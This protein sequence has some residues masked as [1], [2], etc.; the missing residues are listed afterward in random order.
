MKKSIRRIL[1]CSVLIFGC[2]AEALALDKPITAY[3]LLNHSSKSKYLTSAHL[4]PAKKPVMLMNIKLTSQQKQLLQEAN[5]ENKEASEPTELKM[6]PSQYDRGMNG[7]P[8]LDQGMH[9]T[10]AT[11]ANTAAIDALLGKGDYVS[12]LCQLSLGNYFEQKAYL[13]S[14]W[15]GSVGPLVLYQILGFGIINKTNQKIKSCGGLTDYPD[16]D[17]NNRG[18]S[19]SLD[20][21]KELS[22]DLSERLDWQTLLSFE[23]RFAW[24]T[25]NSIKPNALLYKVKEVISSTRSYED[26]RLTFG[27]LLPV[28]YCSAGACARYHAEDDTWALTETIKLDQD[29]Y[30]AGHEMVITGYDDEAVAFDNEGHKHQGLLILRNSWGSDVGDQGNYYMSY[31]FFK[32]YV[33]EVQKITILKY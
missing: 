31:D 19:M 6:L 10:C 5:Y 4:F 8:V 23:Q 17:L 18:G 7:T 29:P 33:V 20:E 12:Q 15:E 11:F 28:N 1:A 21:F 24:E 13:P 14:G 16:H 2:K 32:K 9:G 3:V 26:S 30:L 25:T 22:E 27:A